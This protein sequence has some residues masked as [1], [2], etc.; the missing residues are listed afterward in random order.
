M[1]IIIKVNKIEKNIIRYSVLFILHPTFLLFRYNTLT[2]L[3]PFGCTNTVSPI[4][5]LVLNESPDL[6]AKLSILISK[7]C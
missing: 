7:T 2:V 4:V 6:K 1:S 3:L 5:Y